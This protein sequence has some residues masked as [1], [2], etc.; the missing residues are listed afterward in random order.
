LLG[1]ALAGLKL[2]P[3][4]RAPALPDAAVAERASGLDTDPSLARLALNRPLATPAPDAFGAWQEATRALILTLGASPITPDEQHIAYR[5]LS[6]RAL[7]DGVRQQLIAFR[8]FD[9]S[10]I[11]AYLHLPRGAGPRPGILMV[12]GHA[13][14]GESGIEQLANESG[15][16]QHAAAGQLA[17]LGYLTL[18]PELRGFGYLGQP[19]ATEHRLVAYN[20]ILRGTSYKWIALRDLGVAM[21]VLRGLDE[22]DGERIAVSG[23]SLGG[24]LAVQYSALDPDVDAVVFQSFGGRQ[25]LKQSIH[26]DARDQPHY[27]HVL[28]GID[29]VVAQEHWYWLLAPRPVLGVRGSDNNPFDDGDRDLYGQG[30]SYLGATSNFE[31]R[32][33]EGGHEYFIEPAAEFFARVFGPASP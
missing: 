11:P 26:G 7:A 32:V 1:G 12:P 4:E 8:S 6:E 16:Y 10:E 29:R 9:G 18:T 24:E 27:C 19:F 31:L 20:A 17:R 22:V 13:S 30:W 3:G 21:Q 2:A 25:G 33:A 28:P 15:S 23:A 5:T 14:E